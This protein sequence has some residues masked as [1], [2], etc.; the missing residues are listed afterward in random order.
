MVKHS[1]LRPYKCSVCGKAFKRS[2]EVTS[3]MQIHQ[4]IKYTCEICNFTTTNKVSL[5]THNRR[6]HQKDFRYHCEQCTKGFMSNYDLEDHKASHLGTKTFICEYCG[7]AYSQKSYL[8]AH[9]RV[10]HGIQKSAPKE[11]Q[12]QTCNKS[13]ASEYNL[14]N[15]IGLHSQKFL[16]AHCG[17]EFATN[18]A[19]KLHNRKH[20]GERPYQCKSCSKA[21]ARSAALRVHKLTHTGERP[22]VCDLCG[23]SFTQ[24]SSMMAHRRKHPGIHPPPPPL[25][26]SRLEN[27]VKSE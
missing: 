24:R 10:I 5:R 11:Y 3:H 16:C 8:V 27:S 12:C 7:N 25:L 14:K 18:H 9:K 6:V 17:K 23:Q 4:G 13:F 2:S 20:T 22:Y 26:L 21:F 15:H 1:D 19:L